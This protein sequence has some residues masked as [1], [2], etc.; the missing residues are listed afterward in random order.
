LSRLKGTKA[1]SFSFQT[2]LRELNSGCLILNR[3]GKT[4]MRRIITNYFNMYLPI[5]LA[6]E[7]RKQTHQEVQILKNLA[8]FSCHP[9][10]LLKPFS[11]QLV[12]KS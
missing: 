7:I 6:S 12:N 9:T 11:T 10:F 3:E 5:S 8:I 2:H 4:Q 1:L